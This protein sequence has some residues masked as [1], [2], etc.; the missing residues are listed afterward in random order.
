MQLFELL[1]QSFYG[2]M[3]I[4]NVGKEASGEGVG[5]FFFFFC[6]RPIRFKAALELALDC[7]GSPK[8]VLELDGERLVCVRVSQSS[9][10]LQALRFSVEKP[11]SCN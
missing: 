11:C 5:L 2:P 10:V 7:R 6:C 3:Q 9:I 1:L 4:L 8:V